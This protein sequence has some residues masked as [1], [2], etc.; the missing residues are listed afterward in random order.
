MEPDRHTDAGLGAL[1]ADDF[2]EIGTRGERHDAAAV[3]GWLAQAGRPRY[4]VSEFSTQALADGLV[5]ARYLAQRLDEHGQALQ[6]TWR[7]SVWSRQDNEHW[8][9]RAHQGTAAPHPTHPQTEATA[10]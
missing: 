5:L 7:S 2:L 3:R 8:V 6:G 4:R 1:I 9:L 10:P